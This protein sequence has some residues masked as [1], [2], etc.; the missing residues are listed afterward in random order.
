MLL[1][2][3]IGIPLRGI[4]RNCSQTVQNFS[5]MRVIARNCA[6]LRVIA[7]NCAKFTELTSKIH[8]RWKP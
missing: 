4:A 1:G 8:F 7:W 6:E 2:F 5:E 3:S